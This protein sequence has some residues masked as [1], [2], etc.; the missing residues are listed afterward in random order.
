MAVKNVLI[1]GVSGFLGKGL[2]NHLSSGKEIALFGHSRN[3]EKTAAEFKKHSMKMIGECTAAQLD[4]HRIDCII[5]LAGIAHDLSNQYKPEDYYRV[6]DIG[7][8]KLYDEFLKSKVQKFIFLSSIK[9]AVDTASVPVT[10]AVHCEPV[11]PYGK[12]KHQAELYI[13]QQPLP[14]EKAYFIL[15]PCMVHGHGNK[16]N[17]NLLYRYVNSG[18]PYPL[19][20]FSNQRSFLSADN[21]NF[22]VLQL[23]SRKIEPGVYHLADS[24]F[25][26]TADLYRV[27]AG[28]LGKKARVWNVP[29]PLIRTMFSLIGRKRM[30]TKLT[31][32]MMVSNKKILEQLGQALPVSLTDGLTTTI[33]SFRVS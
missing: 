26:S 10:E 33:R 29:Q 11:T 16:G 1:T 24:G 25:L 13:Q 22:I 20:A 12:S 9:A 17:L 30:L 2:V 27:I 7:T 15:R 23:L 31:E 14:A 18:L 8:R 4:L 19:G 32:D 28:A 5:H 21:F 3:L 6:N